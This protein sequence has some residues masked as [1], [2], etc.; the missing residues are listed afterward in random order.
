MFTPVTLNVYAGPTTKRKGESV[1]EVHATPEPTTTSWSA[2]VTPALADGTYTAVAE[3]SEIGHESEP[4]KSNPV[5][6]TVDTV[7]PVVAITYPASGSSSSGELQLLTGSAGTARHDIQSVTIEVF[8]GSAIPAPPSRPVSTAIVTAS[9]GGWSEVFLLPPG[10]Y[11]ARAVQSDEAGNTGTSAPDTFT[12]TGARPPVAAFSWVP[13]APLAGQ[14]IALISGSTDVSSPITA[15]GWDLAGNGPFKAGGPVLS[16]SFASPG[17]HVVRLQVTDARGASSVAM[18]TIPVSPA[19]LKL[20]Q[21]FPIV[22]IAGIEAR[23]GVRLSSLSVQAP[24]GAHVSVRCAGRG[25][26]MRPQSREARARAHHRSG[27]SVVLAF[28][29]FQHFLPAGV[30]LEVRVSA[31]GEIGKYTRFVIHHHGVPRRVDACLAGLN[32]KP[33]ACPA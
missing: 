3:Q 22:R 20:M 13:P 25:C 29:R 6:L 32:P 21:P 12:L 15:F 10:T 30:R 18:E 31:A 2:T 28:A 14:S 7:P 23:S 27:N 5:T 9:G 33:I 4:S 24:V 16:T 26:R 17:N 11:T 1:R 19:A 8:A